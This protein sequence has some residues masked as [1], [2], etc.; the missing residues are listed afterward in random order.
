MLVF[1]VFCWPKKVHIIF[2]EQSKNREKIIRNNNHHIGEI[3]LN[4]SKA[5]NKKQNMERSWLQ[6]FQKT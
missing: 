6:T 1:Y 4:L 5:E 2:W 3:L